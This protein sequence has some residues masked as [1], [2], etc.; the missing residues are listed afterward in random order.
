M[1]SKNA[2]F[3]A[4]VVVLLI[5]TSFISCRKDNKIDTNPSLLL[6]FSEDTVLFDTVFTNVGSVTERLK[7][8]N[9][10][11]NKVLISTIRLGS[12]G[13]SSFRINIDGT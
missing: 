6:S 4:S 1:T 8:Y 13:S 2:I 11:Q 12:G 5:L 3:N 9:P 10:N 7:V